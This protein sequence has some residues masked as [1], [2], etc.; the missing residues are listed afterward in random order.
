M[1]NRSLITLEE[2]KT[3]AELFQSVYPEL[4]SEI[5]RGE[6]ARG[7]LNDFQL[8]QAVAHAKNGLGVLNYERRQIVNAIFGAFSNIYRKDGRTSAE[9]W[10]IETFG[11]SKKEVKTEEKTEI[12]VKMEELEHLIQVKENELLQIYRE[13]LMLKR[14]LDQSNEIE[15]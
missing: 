13:H 10:A 9:V 15:D 1:E 11:C 8:M 12:I 3:E 6:N 2:M 7:K 5:E 4:S 14:Y